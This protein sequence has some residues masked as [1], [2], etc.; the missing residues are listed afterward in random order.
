M[1]LD[2]L[3]L[4][5]RLDSQLSRS[6]NTRL[7]D[8]DNY[9]MPLSHLPQRLMRSLCWHSTRGNPQRS[10]H[11]LYCRF[12]FVI[13]TAGISPVVKCALRNALPEQNFAAI[14]SA[15]TNGQTRTYNVGLPYGS[16]STGLSTAALGTFVD[17]TYSWWLPSGP[18]TTMQRDRSL[19]LLQRSRDC[20]H[21]TSAAAGQAGGVIGFLITSMDISNDHNS[22]R[23]TPHHHQNLSRVSER[24]TN[25]R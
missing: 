14:C 23:N 18:R 13:T 1:P 12:I 2:H 17:Q 16:A 22:G 24:R 11:F 7:L 21:V 20:F 15:A 5:Y 25:G 19:P 4:K 10:T 8:L 9:V 3:P 6:R